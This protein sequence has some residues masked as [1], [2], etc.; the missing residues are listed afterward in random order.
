MEVK[1]PGKS[2]HRSK[3]FLRKKFFKKI[4]FSLLKR[5]LIRQSKDLRTKCKLGN[6]TKV[7]IEDKTIN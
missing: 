3:M 2:L 1:I 7:D 4:R 6:D 5:I